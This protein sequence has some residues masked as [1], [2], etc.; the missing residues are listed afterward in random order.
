LSAPVNNS[1]LGLPAL[2]VLAMGRS[3]SN[4]GDV[5]CRRCEDVDAAANL[6]VVSPTTMALGRA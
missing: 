2:G 5:L 1:T 3:F 4:A 6:S